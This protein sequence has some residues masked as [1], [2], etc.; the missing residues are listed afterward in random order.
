MASS[1]TPKL[2]AEMRSVKEVKVEE[3]GLTGEFL[4]AYQILNQ[5]FDLVS[6][7]FVLSR[8]DVQY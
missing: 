8:L 6:P 5:E 2:G 3:T 4:K 1:S 7:A